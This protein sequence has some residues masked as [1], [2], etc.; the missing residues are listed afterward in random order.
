MSNRI[1]D[2][3]FLNDE[4]MIESEVSI[5]ID[6]RLVTVKLVIF[7]LGHAALFRLASHNRGS[8]VGS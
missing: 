1:I 5:P 8:Q 6:F 4:F 7:L 2:K 3:N